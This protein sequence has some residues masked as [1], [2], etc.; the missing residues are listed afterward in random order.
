M[1]APA[2]L[3]PPFQEDPR[4]RPIDERTPS[5]DC[6]KC[7]LFQDVGLHA[8]SDARPIGARA[9]PTRQA[10][11]RDAV[12]ILERKSDRYKTAC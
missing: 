9:A 6:A 11:D 2:L 12:A 3:L 7:G 8:N 4:R 10:I 5:N 1:P